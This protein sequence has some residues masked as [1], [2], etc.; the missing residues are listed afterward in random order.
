MQLRIYTGDG[1]AAVHWHLGVATF[2]F[3]PAL[4]K[5]TEKMDQQ[6]NSNTVKFETG[7]F[8]DGMYDVSDTKFEYQPL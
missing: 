3:C 1:S 2:K 8:F 7:P 6:Q 5:Q 4:F